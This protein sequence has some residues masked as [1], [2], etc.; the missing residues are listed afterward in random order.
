MYVIVIT[1]M[2][3]SVSVCGTFPDEYQA[4]LVANQVETEESGLAT[5]VTMLDSPADV[6]A[7]L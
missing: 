3:G 2:D 7:G 5:F 4:T 1:A 6:L